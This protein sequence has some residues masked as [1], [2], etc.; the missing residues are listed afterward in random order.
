MGGAYRKG[1]MDT[2]LS[3]NLEVKMVSPEEFAANAKK[4]GYREVSRNKDGVIVVQESDR[5]QYTSGIIPNKNEHAMGHS[6][7]ESKEDFFLAAKIKSDGSLQANNARATAH[8]KS[9]GK[10]FQPVQDSSGRIINARI[11]MSNADKAEHLGMDSSI[12]T[13]LSNQIM[14]AKRNLEYHQLTREIDEE[15]QG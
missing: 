5:V 14:S 12:G 3:P 7:Y 15:R 6:K 11:M 2:N 10:D 4:Q 13:V 1:Y 9:L 8:I